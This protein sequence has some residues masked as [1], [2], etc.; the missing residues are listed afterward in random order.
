MNAY[1]VLDEIQEVPKALTSLKYFNENA[2]E[3]HIVAAGSLLGIALH[4]GGSFPVGKV[5]TLDLYPLSFEEFVQAQAGK[6]M[7]DILA[8]NDPS[9]A[10]TFRSKLEPLLKNHYYVGGMP[11]AVESFGREANYAEA[12]AGLAHIVPRVTKPGSA[13]TQILSFR[14]SRRKLAA[15]RSTLPGG[16]RTALADDLL[17]TAGFRR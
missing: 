4:E 14:L 17:E 8:N 2:P 1:I 7:A 10:V 5:E 3:Y 12:R 13:R 9:M 16:E 15:Q 6:P 11:E